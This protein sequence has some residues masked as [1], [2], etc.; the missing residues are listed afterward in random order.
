MLTTS[1]I[2]AGI[3]S[4]LFFLLSPGVLLTLPPNNSCNV[5]MQLH[6]NNDECATSYQAALVHSVVF[7]I[8]ALLVIHMVCSMLNK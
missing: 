5:F 6:K 2:C 1:L 7:F 4:V 3:L 8:V